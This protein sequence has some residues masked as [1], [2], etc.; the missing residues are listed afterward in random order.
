MVATSDTKGIEEPSAVTTVG[1]DLPSNS[2]GPTPLPQA[3]IKSSLKP[4]PPIAVEPLQGTPP[5]R[6]G[7]GLTFENGVRKM[8]VPNINKELPPIMPGRD[9]SDTE[10]GEMHDGFR[11]SKEYVAA[12]EEAAIAKSTAIFSTGTA[13]PPAGLSHPDAAGLVPKQV[14]FADA[15]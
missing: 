6:E 5:Q 12:D 8:S 10:W 4:L 3:V 7:A 11:D 13:T 9:N 15:V 14:S 2:E 1:D